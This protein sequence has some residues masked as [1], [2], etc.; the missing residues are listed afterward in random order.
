MGQPALTGN[1][2]HH[3]VIDINH[4]EATMGLVLDRLAA[5]EGG[6]LTRA[7]VAAAMGEGIERAF[8]NPATWCGAG[9]GLRRAA[10]AQAGPWLVKAL[11]R[12]AVRTIIL[13]GVG[14]VIYQFGGWTA[15]AAA[16]KA[17][18]GGQS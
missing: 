12:F 16:W 5:V 13:C 14:V 17:F 9:D 15:L 3:V 1:V 6:Q 2:P 11:L 18:G 4:F 8:A 10:E 7:D